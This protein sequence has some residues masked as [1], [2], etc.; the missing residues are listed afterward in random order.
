MGRK[1]IVYSESDKAALLYRERD[2][3]NAPVIALTTGRSR[4]E[5]LGENRPL[6]LLSVCTRH[7]HIDFGFIFL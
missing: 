6:G 2:I 7:A 4:R 3:S 5:W 1:I